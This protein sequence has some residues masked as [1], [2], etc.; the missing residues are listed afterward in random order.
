MRK[1]ALQKEDL[2]QIQV[3]GKLK[4]ATFKYNNNEIIFE[5]NDSGNI[6]AIYYEIDTERDRIIG[7]DIFNY[8]TIRLIKETLDNA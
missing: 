6:K 8:D 7:L 2:Q 3:F 5:I 4:I 1:I